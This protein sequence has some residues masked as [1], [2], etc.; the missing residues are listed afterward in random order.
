MKFYLSSLKLGNKKDELKKWIEDHDNKICLISNARNVY[1]DG[2][3]KTSKIHLNV[4][5]LT[6]LEFE[7]TILS[8][9]D[10]FN[11]KNELVKSL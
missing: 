9:K 7:V 8:L 1:L 6:H 4:Q 5:E 10:Y 11:K 3:R 2:E